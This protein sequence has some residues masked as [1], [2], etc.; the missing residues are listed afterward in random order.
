MSERNRPVGPRAT[1]RPR[2]S[3]SGAGRS[4]G[5]A[6]SR[7][8]SV[9]AATPT[10]AS[11]SA[12]GWAIERR[13][14]AV[15]HEARA[16]LGPLLGQLA[17]HGS[18]VAWRF[19]RQDPG[20]FPDTERPV[21]LAWRPVRRLP[22]AAVAR[23]RGDRDAAVAALIEPL[24]AL[25]V[26]LGRRIDNASATPVAVPARP[27]AAVTV[28][29]LIRGAKDEE[30]ASA[31]APAAPPANARR[32]ADRGRL[33][34]DG[35]DGRRRARAAPSHRYRCSGLHFRLGAQH[36]LRGHPGDRRGPVRPRLPAA[37]AGLE[38]MVAGSTTPR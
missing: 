4:R 16:A 10:C 29:V 20:S 19:D 25:A 6:G 5:S 14:A 1:R 17:R 8:G 30:R 23:V 12:A 21:G 13:P 35:R 31:A 11:A 36:R 33:G 15:G 38:R 3:R 32:P 37:T 24:W 22:G 18:G 9:R 27:V 26:T 34:L 7:R 28:T 2:T